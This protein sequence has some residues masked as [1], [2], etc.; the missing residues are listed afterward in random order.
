MNIPV[1]QYWNLLRKYLIPLKNKVAWLM[2]LILASIGLQLLMPQIIR[3]FIDTAQ[4]IVPLENL[5]RLALLF[6]GAALLQQVAAVLSTYASE[7]IAWS[8]TN[9]LRVDLAE[10]CLGLDMS[11]HKAHTPGELI[12][13]LDGDVTTLSNF[14]SQFVTQLI[15]N[16]ILLLG[17]LVILFFE[18][19]WVGVA[20][21]AFSLTAIFVMIRFRNLA[22]V[23]WKA[24]REASAEMY[25]FL[26]E[27]LSGTED[28][29]ANGAKAY[30]MRSFYRLTSNLMNRS[31]KAGLMNNIL[32]NTIRL[33]FSA[34]VAISFAL[35]AAF[36]KQEII[37]LG[38]VYLIFHYTN[39]LE[40]PIYLI[41]RQIEDLQK[42]GAGILRVQE[43]FNRKTRIQEISLTDPRAAILTR[44][45]G[46]ALSVTFE[47]VSFSYQDEEK[48]AGIQASG[49]NGNGQE[50]PAA[51]SQTDEGSEDE[52][53]LK[54]L[55]FTLQAG[56]ILGL[57]GR[58]GSGK[59]TLI[60]LL[61]R[62]YDPDQGRIL[63][64]E[65][66]RTPA[67]LDHLPLHLLRQHIGMVTQN[68]QLFHASVRDNLTFFNDAVP[69]E[70]I[71]EVIETLGLVDWLESL[72]D[73]LNTEIASGGKRLSAGEAQ[74]LAF[75]RIFLK[76]PGLV[77]LDEASS[78][79]DPA[80]EALI[81]RA[82]S[83]LV[84]D[85]TAIIIAHRLGTVS[86]A[87]KIMILQDAGILEF[88]E[89]ERLAK[90][91]DSHFH[92]LLQ[93]GLEEVL[94]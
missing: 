29:V 70:K 82:I 79:L 92:H 26:E 58:T 74:L 42:A 13:R 33:L 73:G 19:V 23:H 31:L 50:E 12:E 77:I 5:L 72:P 44:R 43:L 46:N 65:P 78:R 69:D 24:E 8:S 36:F 47:N 18:D 62:L 54:G 87:G 81:E 37:S 4:S 94:A 67:Q 53:V 39:L 6:L 1:S 25:G 20:L 75:T 51:I 90:D 17:I 45:R 52:S 66:G 9:A 41:T 68:I 16:G 55:S 40:D 91:P 57:L 88:G 61:F 32:I 76:D 49:S 63:L 60:N 59:T 7:N 11:F 10:H 56:D 86:R 15:G 89:R 84:E 27:R 71:M 80:T 48:P 14:F 28:I 30:T 21:T 85:R 2:F 3:Q 64:G 93:T 34:A 83:R 38:T 22:V 35:G